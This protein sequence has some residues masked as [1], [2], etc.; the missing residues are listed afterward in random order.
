[1]KLRKRISQG[2]LESAAVVKLVGPMSPGNRTKSLGK[3]DFK[4]VTVIPATFMS[5]GLDAPFCRFFS[6]QKNYV[7]N[8]AGKIIL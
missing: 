1:M 4:Q 8:H 5:S 7:V 2:I 6:F 3:G